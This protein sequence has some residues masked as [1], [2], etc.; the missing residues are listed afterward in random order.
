[1]QNLSNKKCVPC[2]V[3]PGASGAHL[4]ANEI[5]ELYKQVEHWEIVDY[6]HLKR[7]F[8]FKNFAEALV[9]V[10]KVGSLAE[11]ESHHPDITFGWGYAEIT[12]FTH[13]IDGLS[14]NDFILA[15]KIDTLLS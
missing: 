9:F 12:S 14:E 5:E 6:H 1:M 3:G 15:A 4:M 8:T 11:S 13:A 2:E 10:T 7:R